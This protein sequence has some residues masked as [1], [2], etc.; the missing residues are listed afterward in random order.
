MHRTGLIKDANLCDHLKGAI[1]FLL[2]IGNLIEEI[3]KING[4][5]N[6]YKEAV[7]SHV[8]NLI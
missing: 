1:L 6:F 2:R 8:N 3:E 4:R 7:K 5:S